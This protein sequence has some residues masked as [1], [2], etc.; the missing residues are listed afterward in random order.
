MKPRPITALLI[1]QFIAF[2]ASAQSVE[3]EMNKSRPS[4]FDMLQNASDL[5]P[6][7]YRKQSF[8][9]MHYAIGIWKKQCHNV[10]EIKYTEI[11]LAI[12]ERKFSVR[13]RF[14]SSN[15]QLLTQYA[16]TLSMCNRYRGM[17]AEFVSYYK[18]S[19]TWAKILLETETL[20]SNE[21]FV[22]KVFA[23]DILNPE[24]E[25]RQNQSAYPVFNDLLKEDFAIERSSPKSNF[26]LT[27]GVWIP[28]GNLSA[29]R[30]HP[31]LGLQIGAR[32]KKH[33]LDLGL[34]LKFA[35]TANYYVK[36][37]DSLY[38]RNYFLGGYIGLDYTYY[39]VSRPRFDVGWVAGI[40]YDGF[41]IAPR[42][43]ENNDTHYLDPVSISSLNINTGARINFYVTKSFYIGLQTRYNA[44]NYCNTGGTDFGGGA[45]S[46]DLIFGG[47]TKDNY[48]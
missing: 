15:I 37:N 16:S 25:I 32:S 34:Y 31:T 21:R 4:C 36:R 40:G 12:S 27:A 11:L 30:S 6:K 22:C 19:S 43:T 48:R 38:S 13:Q 42:S 29:V 20:D 9:S 45:F 33:E 7:L 8:D 44:V 23:G 41:D 18:F 10:P 39:F 1:L 14:D 5:L 3:Q 28:R 2:Y 26:A 35:N 24:K 17:S 46:I 47:N